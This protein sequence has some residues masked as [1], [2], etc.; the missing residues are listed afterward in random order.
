MNLKV[1]KFELLYAVHEKCVCDDYE[2][3]FNFVIDLSLRINLNLKLLNSELLKR[4]RRISHSSS[5]CRNC[6]DSCSQCHF[7]LLLL[8]RR[9]TYVQISKCLL[10]FICSFFA[11][12]CLILNYLEFQNKT[13]SDVDCLL[14]SSYSTKISDLKSAR[15]RG[16][17]HCG[18]QSIR[19]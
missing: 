15:T 4:T 2:I 17:N 18:G 12:N 6:L 9:S 16:F 19:W 3:S 5:S 13:T 10:Q 1:A 11:R 14:P 7:V 8:A